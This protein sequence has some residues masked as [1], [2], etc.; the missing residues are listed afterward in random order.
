MFASPLLRFGFFIFLLAGC[1]HAK[2]ELPVFSQNLECSREEL[3]LFIQPTR[4]IEDGNGLEIIYCNRRETPSGK[5]IE[6]SLVF[7]D[8]RHPSFW[9]DEVYRI[10]RG[11][12]YGRH[13]D[14]E[15]IRLHF[16][17]T[18]ELST[19]HLKNVYSGEQRFA[20]DPVRHFDSVLK[21]EQLMKEE[22]KPVLFI[23]TWNH[24]LSEKDLNPE[25]SKKKLDSVELRT[26]SREELDAFYSGK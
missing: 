4:D 5:K 10:Y 2:N 9:K 15:S 7:Q 3:P 24:M 16:S 17:E 13:K 22:R 1:S 25:L 21:S 18:G 23:N 19:V 6:L 12:K 14:I 11:F 20:E 8:E 26:G